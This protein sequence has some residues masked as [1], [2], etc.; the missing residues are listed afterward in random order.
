MFTQQSLNGNL[1]PN[2]IKPQLIYPM[3][4]GKYVTDSEWHEECTEDC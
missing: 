1:C 2:T 4:V 3:N